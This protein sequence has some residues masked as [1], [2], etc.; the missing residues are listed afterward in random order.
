M[1]DERP[2][3]VRGCFN[4]QPPIIRREAKASDGYVY[5]VLAIEF[6]ETIERRL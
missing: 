6:I 3:A 5:G 1:P 4:P 2:D